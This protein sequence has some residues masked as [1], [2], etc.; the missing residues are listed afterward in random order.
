MGIYHEFLSARDDTV[1]KQGKVSSQ[2]HCTMSLNVSV[3]SCWFQ[4]A[5]QNGV[6]L[7]EHQLCF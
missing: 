1:R 3:V 2:F 7:V 5:Q 6:H 4:Q